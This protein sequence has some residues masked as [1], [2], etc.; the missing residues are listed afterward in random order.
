MLKII[1]LVLPFLMLLQSCGGLEYSPNQVFSGDSPRDINQKSIRRLNEKP[2]DT[3]I[4]FIITGDSQRAY[5]DAK[6]LVDAVNRLPEIDFVVLNGDISDFGLYQEMESVDHIFS[7]LSSP[8]IG[9]IGNHDLVANGE[10][11][12]KR[13]FGEL[14]FSFN[15]QGVKF[16]C[17]NTNSRESSFSGNV[18]DMAWLYQ[19][20]LPEDGIDAYIAIAHVP[21]GDA[22]FDKTLEAEYVGIINNSPNTLAALFAHTHNHRVF[23][24]GFQ[25]HIPY[26]ITDPIEKRK[27]TLIE[28]F[29]GKLK[30]ENFA[31]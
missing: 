17:H 27:F 13:M 16:V 31:Y 28:I 6:D 15:Y 4:R 2:A 18:P 30:Y 10:K 24:P 9:V 5:K 1:K 22:D 23:Y 8:Y 29:D 19:Q 11:I 12:Y 25:E 7:K 20:F 26:I 14:N 3:R 21:P